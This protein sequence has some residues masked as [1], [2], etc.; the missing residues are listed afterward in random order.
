MKVSPEDLQID[1]VLAQDIKDA[2]GQLLVPSGQPI[3]EK[4]LRIFRM[5]GVGEV[6]IEGEGASPEEPAH[7]DPA[8]LAAAEERLRPRFRHT[9]LEHPVIEALFRHCSL[10]EAKRA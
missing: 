4:H 2:G 9:D 8:K 7:I 5:I 10:A 3:T 6:E 1:M